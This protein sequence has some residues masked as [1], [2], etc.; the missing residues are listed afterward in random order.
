MEPAT[1]SLHF[2]FSCPLS[3]WETVTPHPFPTSTPLPIPTVAE[4]T[5]PETR[6]GMGCVTSFSGCPFPVLINRRRR[7]RVFWV[8]LHQ[9]LLHHFLTVRSQHWR[10]R[11]FQLSRS[12][13]HFSL[14]VP[15]ILGHLSVRLEDP[16]LS[17]FRNWFWWFV[18]DSLDTAYLHSFLSLHQQLEVC[19][20]LLHA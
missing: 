5:L 8:V 17:S 11:V 7:R 4:S 14:L 3:Y 10:R 12:E 2:R 16:L 15:M 13:V 18:L 20:V 19:S 9:V 1:F 6:A